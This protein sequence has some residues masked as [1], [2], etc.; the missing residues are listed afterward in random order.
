MKKIAVKYDVITGFQYNMVE[1]PSVRIETPFATP[2]TRKATKTGLNRRILTQNKVIPETTTNRTTVTL[3]VIEPSSDAKTPLVQNNPCL[4]AVRKRCDKKR[5]I[6]LDKARKEKQTRQA[7]NF[8]KMAEPELLDLD[9]TKILPI[10]LRA[11]GL[12][13]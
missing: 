7:V 11:N 13:R 3:L 12:E 8:P 9:I 10:D 5:T 6:A 1:I 2:Q 4:D